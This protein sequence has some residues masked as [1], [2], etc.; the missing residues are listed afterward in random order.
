M[1]GFII[2]AAGVGAAA[3]YFRSDIEALF[4]KSSTTTTS[5]TPPAS[6]APKPV[7]VATSTSTAP[8]STG[9][10]GFRWFKRPASRAPIVASPSAPATPAVP[11]SAPS[12]TTPP[13]SGTSK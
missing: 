4:K 8:S 5:P 10:P 12:S 2:V 7:P 1:L 3:Y 11:P 6:T 13:A 9:I